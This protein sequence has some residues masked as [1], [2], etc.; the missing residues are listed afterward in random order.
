MIT[1]W[2]GGVD[3][4]QEEEQGAA[5]MAPSESLLIL[6]KDKSI[7]HGVQGR[8]GSSLPSSAFPKPCL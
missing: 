8:L 4:W 6:C 2:E 5:P 7:A 1:T 3:A